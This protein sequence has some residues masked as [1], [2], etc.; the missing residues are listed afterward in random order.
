MS[1]RIR[2]IVCI[3]G[4][5]GVSVVLSGLKKC[6]IN[7]SAIVSMADSGGSNRVIRDEFGLLPTSDLRQ[8]FVALA[9]D[10]NDPEQS[11]RKLFTYRFNKGRGFKG[12]TFG[13][14]FMIALTDIF[15]S[16]IEAIKKTSQI[17]KI[18]GKVLPV[19]LID[20]NLVAIYEDGTKVVGEHFI[21]EP[22]HDGRLKIKKIYLQPKTKTYPEVIQA[23][24]K[25]DLIVI[26]PGDLYTSLIVNLLVKR[27]AEALR[28]TRGK[29]VFVLNLMTKYGQTYG[30]TAKDH[31]RTL[32]K[33]LGK[34]RLDFVLVN[35]KPFPEV[36]L[37]KYKKEQE[38]PVI[39]DLED[40]YFK[41]IRSDFF[42]KKETKKIPSDTLK[43]SLIRHDPNKLARVI[44]SLI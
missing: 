31:I 33:Y 43:R 9:E 36:A 14:L 44:L 38:F 41:V 22:K 35:S 18:K 12:M 42:S 28:K 32:E 3:G 24:L 34:N 26:G 39:D 1:K 11:L 6:P 20:S 23:I 2:K 19:T 30:F 4:G 8:C 17:L 29:I 21:D 40:N 5:T 15:G 7:L 25:A 16:Q 10:S 37:K 27:I 13:N